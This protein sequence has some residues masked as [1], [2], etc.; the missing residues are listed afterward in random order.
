MA[1]HVV[2]SM[3]EQ[4]GGA[5]VNI[6]S[7]GAFMSTGSTPAYGATKAALIRL[8]GDLA[9]AYGRNNIRVNAIAPGNIYTPMV[10]GMMDAKARAQRAAA[11]ALGTEG[12]AW[13]VAWAAVFLASDE[14]RWITGATL[15][16]DG[17]M[18]QTNPLAIHRTLEALEAEEESS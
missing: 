5:I 9:V 18:S 3:I 1:K 13:D 15:P 6:S 16:V 2:P 11:S 14:A 8:T 7:T 4:G 12:T 10:A 17:G